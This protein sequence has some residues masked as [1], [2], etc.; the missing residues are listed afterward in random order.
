MDM[1][2]HEEAKRLGKEIIYLESI[3]EQIEAMEGIPFDAIVDFLQRI[4]EWDAIVRGHPRRFMRGDLDGVLRV[5]G[6][7]PTRC[8][9]IIDCRDPV[10]FERMVPYLERG[11]AAVLV[12]TSHIPGLIR[13]LE[14]AGW[15]VRPVGR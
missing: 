10:F 7:F 14:E 15:S 3:E 2:A 1:E 11:G 13:R 9:S 5:V 12:G 6:R 8:E 4:D